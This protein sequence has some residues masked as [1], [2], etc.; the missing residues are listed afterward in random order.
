MTEVRVRICYVALKL[1]SQAIPWT[2]GQR[3]HRV[4]SF[5]LLSLPLTVAIWGREGGLQNCIEMRCRNVADYVKQ[6]EHCSLLSD[7]K[8]THNCRG[9]VKGKFN[10]LSATRFAELLLF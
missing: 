5:R 6:A 2:G 8:H 9:R 10:L 4:L 3:G 7:S 1:A